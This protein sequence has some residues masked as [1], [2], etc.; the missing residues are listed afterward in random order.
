MLIVSHKA[1]LRVLLCALLGIDVDLFR[2][3][4][5]QR[6]GAISVVELRKS[7][8][9]LDRLGDIAHLPPELAAGDGT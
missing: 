8:P 1:T 9:L 4:V 7:G 2:V 6:V 5:G 3:R